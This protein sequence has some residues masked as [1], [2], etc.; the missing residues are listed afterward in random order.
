M[1]HKKPVLIA[2]AKARNRRYGI[3]VTE[4]ALERMEQRGI[5]SYNVCE[6]IEALGEDVIHYLV[7]NN[8]QAIICNKHRGCAIVTQFLDSIIRV[9]TVLHDLERP[10][11]GAVYYVGVKETA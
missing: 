1:N 4:H 2:Q 10:L 5:S 11:R 7:K 9:I 8:E 3:F 6:N